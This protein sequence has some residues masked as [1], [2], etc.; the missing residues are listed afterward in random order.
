[1]PDN[2]FPD[3]DYVR[4]R[5]DEALAEDGAGEDCTVSFLDIGA[6]PIAAV[7][8]AGDSGVIAGLDV[9]RM[10]FTHLDP[11]TRFDASIQDGDAVQPG[12]LIAE[13]GGR[14]GGIMPA[15]RVAL[16]F[17]QRLSGV[18]T[19]TARFVEE[20]RGT[21]VRILDTRKTT[22]LFRP[23][24]RHAVRVG[25]GVNHRFNLSDMIL[26]KE[27]HMRSVGGMESIRDIVSRAVSDKEIEVEVDTVDF[28]RILLGS[29]VDRIMLDNFR[30]SDVREAIDTINAY[31][32]DHPG[33]TPRIEVS[34]GVNIDNILEYAIDGV[35]D[36]SIG[37]LTHSAPAM[38][39]SLEV[40]P[41]GT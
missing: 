40:T 11:E 25:G 8:I 9:A 16:N 4:G 29:P 21:G 31:R 5:I 33:F 37:A 10:T 34:G 18:A 22:P 6:T 17:L 26:I 24:E 28:L 1:M 39:I 14:A 13:L 19:L 15:E 38:N 23:L 2:V 12:D 3:D 36:I 20:V 35:D 41:R 27:N 32:A 30:P 7:I